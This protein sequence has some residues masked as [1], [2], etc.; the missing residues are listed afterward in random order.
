LNKQNFDGDDDGWP[1]AEDF[2]EEGKTVMGRTKLG[3]LLPGSTE[4]ARFRATFGVSAQVAADAY[5]LME[6]L[7]V[8]PPDPSPR[9]FLWA[10]AFM[11]LYP[12]NDKALSLILGNKDPKT[13]HKYLWPYIR[14]LFE[15]DEH[16]VSH[17]YFANDLFDSSDLDSNSISDCLC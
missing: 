3:I 14:S 16:V 10:L 4:D 17:L 13:L 12:K 7:D 6:T 8:L 5:K 15:L 2:Y 11:C 1:T 9:H